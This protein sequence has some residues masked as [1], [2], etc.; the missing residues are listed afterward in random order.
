MNNGRRRTLAGL[1]DLLVPGADGMP[2]ASDAGVSGAG[3]DRLL[4]ALPDLEAPLEALLDEAAGREP[5]AALAALH[6][7][8]RAAVLEI[9]TAGSYLTDGEV[10]ALL[11]YGGREATP[12]ADDLDDEVVELLESVLARGRAYR[13]A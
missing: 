5:E 10:A 1:A 3:L 7:E 13:E 4:E 8:G 2:S 11:G 9:V 12:L 6:R